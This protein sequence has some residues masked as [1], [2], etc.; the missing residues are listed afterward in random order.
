MR[1]VYAVH[2]CSACAVHVCSAWAVHGPRGAH[3]V[4]RP[5]QHRA[6][7]LAL[8]ARPLVQHVVRGVLCKVAHKLH[9]RQ[10]VGMR[11][12]AAA[13]ERSPLGAALFDAFRLVL[14]AVEAG[15]V[16]DD[17]CVQSAAQAEKVQHREERTPGHVQHCADVHA[18]HQENIVGLRRHLL[19]RA[20]AGRRLGLSNRLTA[21]LLVGAEQAL[22]ELRLAAAHL[23]TGGTAPL[24]EQWHRQLPEVIAARAHGGVPVWA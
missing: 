23:Q 24:L 1:R 16:E 15:A 7:T 14:H 19:A 2:V 20:R 4:K 6:T 17:R 8:G 5:H 21:R 13:G 12:G 11:R 18:V 9:R 10:P 3:L 22:H